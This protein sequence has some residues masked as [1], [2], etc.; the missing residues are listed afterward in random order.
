[1]LET[2]L[3]NTLQ[4]CIFKNLIISIQTF[5]FLLDGNVNEEKK[6]DGTKRKK[7][8]MYLKA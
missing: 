5:T 6:E 1:M 8:K 2:N 7:E 3:Q 4:I